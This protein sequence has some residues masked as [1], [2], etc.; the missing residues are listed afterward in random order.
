MPE[1]LI[2]RKIQQLITT[3]QIHFSGMCNEKNMI[4]ELQDVLMQMDQLS[5]RVLKYILFHL[6][7]VSEVKGNQK[8][9]NKRKQTIDKR[10]TNVNKFY[11]A[12][13]S[14]LYYLFATNFIH[15]RKGY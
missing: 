15:Q 11:R 13:S 12:F 2:P 9:C 8:L 10:V 1:P 4:A 14:L 6:K 5:Y 7:D 3:S